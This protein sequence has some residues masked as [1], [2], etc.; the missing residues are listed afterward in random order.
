VA[1]WQQK[2][3]TAGGLALSVLGCGIERVTS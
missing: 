3:Q 2:S 1:S